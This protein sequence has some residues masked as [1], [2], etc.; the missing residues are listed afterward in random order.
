MTKTITEELEAFRRAN[1]LNLD[2]DSRPIWMAQLGRFVFPL[3]N[4]RWRRNLINRHDAHHLICECSTSAYD[5][6]ELATWELGARCFKDWRAIA[7]CRMLAFFGLLVQPKITYRAYKRGQS[8]SQAYADLRA[9]GFFD[10]SVTTARS[11]LA[12]S[13]LGAG[14]SSSSLC[15]AGTSGPG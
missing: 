12:G 11:I 6:L 4:F 9:L 13:Y 5:E 3:P 7:L 8:Q 14:A 1:G 15:A 10:L 2:E